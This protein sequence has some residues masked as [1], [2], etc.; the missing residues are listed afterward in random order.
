[1]ATII[2]LLIFLA[3]AWLA[4]AGFR[5]VMLASVSFNQRLSITVATPDGPR[6]SSVETRLKAA[7]PSIIGGPGV[8]PSGGPG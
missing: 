4:D 6:T 5:K 2:A 7:P 8:P 3:L 1:M